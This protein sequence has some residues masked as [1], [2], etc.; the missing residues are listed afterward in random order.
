[1]RGGVTWGHFSILPSCYSARGCRATYTSFVNLNFLVS[2]VRQGW[3]SRE[4]SGTIAWEKSAGMGT[5]SGACRAG[6][7]AAAG[8]PSGSKRAPCDLH[9]VTCSPD[10]PSA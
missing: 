7:G 6:P 2:V 5:R 8:W 4:V 1:M 10:L 3:N 9:M